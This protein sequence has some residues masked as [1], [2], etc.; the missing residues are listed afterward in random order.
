MT[1]DIKNYLKV[2]EDQGIII[3]PKQIN[4][5]F[6]IVKLFGYPYKDKAYYNG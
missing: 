5:E 2:K 6:E 4:A 1:A 3:R